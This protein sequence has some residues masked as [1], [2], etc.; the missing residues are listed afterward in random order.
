MKIDVCQITGDATKQYG[1]NTF[2]S[3]LKF[4]VPKDD[5]LTMNNTKTTRK[6]N[7]YNN[8]CLIL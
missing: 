3:K 8:F 7:F 2:L 1:A 4:C 5:Q 6:L